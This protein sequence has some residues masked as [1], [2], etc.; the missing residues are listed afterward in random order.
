MSGAAAGAVIT[1]IQ[2][3]QSTSYRDRGIARYTFELVDAVRRRD[4]SVYAALVLNPD[5]AAPTFIEP[6]I[7]SRLLRFSDEVDLGDAAVW[8]VTS[9]Y[10]LTVAPERL[11]PRRA[12]EAGL[13][14]V[15][16][17]H[18]LIPERMASHYLAD[19]GIRAR[20]RAR[21]ELV[22]SADRVLAVSQ[23][24]ADDVVDLLG[25][26]PSRVAVTGEGVSDAF[27]P[28]HG[29]ERGA[30]AARAAGVV[31]GLGARFVLYT[32]GVDERKNLDRL[33]EAWARVPSALRSDRKLAVV[34]RLVPSAR[35]HYDVM[36][37][38]LGISGSLVLTGYVSDEVLRDLYRGCELMV[39]PSTYE[40]YGLPVAEAWACGAPVIGSSTTAVAELLSPSA[41]FEPTDVGAMRDAI[42]RALTDEAHRAE[43]FAW[44]AQPPPSWSV[45]ADATLDVYREEAHRGRRAARRRR[46]ARRGLLRVGFATPLPPA[47]TGVA[48]FSFH[49]LGQ[50][51]EH[52]D[53][54]ALY[55]RPGDDGAPEGVA[56]YPARH[57]RQIEAARGGYDRVVYSL[58]NSE[59]HT[60]ALAQLR[61]RPGVVLAHDVRLS[62][63]FFYGAHQDEAVP[64]G[65]HGVIRDAYGDTVPDALGRD[66]PVAP[67]DVAR[68]G[69]YLARAVAPYAEPLVVMST[70]A[71]GLARADLGP[72]LS[73]R[74][75]QLP[76]AVRPAPEGARDDSGPP[77][78]VSFGVVNRVKR[79]DVV[80]RAFAI[81]ARSHADA[82]LVFVGPVSVRDRADVEA[83]ARDEGLETRVEVAGDFE[84]REYDQ[85]LLRATLAV[86]LRAFSNGE[87]SGAIGDSLSAGT[88]TI[89]AA[90]GPSRDLPDDVVVKV[91]SD[92]TPEA[93]APAID[94]LLSDRNRRDELGRR[95]A[96]WAAANGHAQL[97]R[98][99]YERV[100][101]PS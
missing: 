94:A 14:I 73:S 80:V 2:G 12:Q 48:D 65:L 96:A 41:R 7:A 76:F 47:L 18:D 90:V 66:G 64:E 25:I 21:H 56:A 67:T 30:A 15:V 81:V 97:A 49:F 100:L 37:E 34:C 75:V 26:D 9:P 10:E 68:Y 89:A 54:D 93:L 50:L 72:R 55:E 78:V 83:V 27:T 35:H 19:A 39:F 57:L 88:P 11:V 38:R 32:G 99:L 95:G 51:R 59:F 20:Y 1:D 4:P 91:A 42:V 16:T 40:G 13:R 98:L 28:A 17:V 33:L 86:Q 79:P 44:S 6:L 52:C 85:W 84:Q 3:L 61:R 8:H 62:D 101:A 22:R 29:D 24:T 43:L 77:I 36:A 60:A 23:T 69:T 31:E 63:L 53:V 70:Y 58:G 82:R 92:V 5:L 46:G 71:A 45:A 87:S 74:L